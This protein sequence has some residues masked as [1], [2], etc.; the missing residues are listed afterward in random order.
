ME[1]PEKGK[2]IFEPVQIGRA[3]EDIVLQVEAA[4]LEGRLNP[5]DRLPSERELQLQFHTGRGVVREAFRVL[6]QKGLIE[7]KKGAR[8]GAFVKD[9]DVAIVSESFALF[10]K[11]KKVSPEETI[12][13]RE[14]IDQAIAVLAIARGS[15][16][17]KRRLVDLAMQLEEIAADKSPERE[18]T[19]AVDRE[20]NI[21]LAS[22]TG[23]PIFEWVMRAMQSGFSSYDYAL[24]DDPK[25]REMTVKNWRATAREIAAG[26]PVKTAT[27]ISFHYQLLRQ[28]IEEMG[29]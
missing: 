11:Q 19:G 27:C 23:N 22:M 6:Q 3:G 28:C 16:D 13:F 17:D 7:V 14:S 9:A 29:K 10:L 26:E 20:L 1:I 5:G 24:Y 4:I 2:I 18:R 8:G 15:G 25:Y 21:L 12:E